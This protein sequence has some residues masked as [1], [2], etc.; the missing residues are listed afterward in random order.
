MDHAGGWVDTITCSNRTSEVI[1]MR[2]D[3]GSWQQIHNPTLKTT[4]TD[5]F[6]P[7]E[8][9]TSRV[10]RHSTVKMPRPLGGAVYCIV[11]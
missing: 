6:E 1:E 5:S 2:G 11:H 9:F 8:P 10:N 3:R 7:G 4:D